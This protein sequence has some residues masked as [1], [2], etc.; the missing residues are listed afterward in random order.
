MSERISAIRTVGSFGT[1]RPRAG[2][3]LPRSSTGKP[4]HSQQNLR[5]TSLQSFT[6]VLIG[7]LATAVLVTL[8]AVLVHRGAISTGDA[9]A[10][11]TYLGLL[12][13]PLIRLTQF[14]GGI[15][16]TLAAVDRITE[17]LDEPEPAAAQPSACRGGFAVDLR[18]RNV[19][20]AYEPQGPLVLEGS[21]CA[22][23]RE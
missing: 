6:A 23:S 9:V 20:F 3:V 22:S 14:Y 12:Y 17:V 7:G 8:A 15:T 13:Q 5:A 4:T 10:F 19:S 18:L 21:I 1:E 16:A 11:V 2:R